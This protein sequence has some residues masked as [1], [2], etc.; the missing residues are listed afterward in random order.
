MM[1]TSMTTVVLMFLAGAVAGI[2]AAAVARATAGR[3]RHVQVVLIV[4]AA[5]AV[6][7]AAWLAV[8]VFG[9]GAALRNM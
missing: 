2:L 4:F 6:A 7:F 1:E 3:P 5:L 8:M 9:V